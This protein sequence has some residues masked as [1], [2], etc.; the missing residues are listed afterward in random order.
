MSSAEEV[1]RADG[2]KCV[3]DASALIAWLSDEKGGEIVETMLPAAISASNMVEVYSKAFR[4]GLSI[5]EVRAALAEL[6]LQLHPFDEDQIPG[7]ASIHGQTRQLNFSLAD[8]IC[9][10]LAAMLGLPAL[11]GDRKWAEVKLPAKITLIR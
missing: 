9:I 5:D 2:L 8:C 7:A 11:T 4:S 6:P 10:N 1:V 3:L